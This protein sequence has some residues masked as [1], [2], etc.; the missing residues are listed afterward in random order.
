MRATLSGDSAHGFTRTHA[1]HAGALDQHQ[2]GFRHADAAGEADHQKPRAPC[3]AAQAV[4]E[5][6]PAHRIEH[7]HIAPRPSVMR[8]TASLNGSRP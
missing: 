7:R 8:F 2:I 5:D 4:F 1:E 3:D 6:R